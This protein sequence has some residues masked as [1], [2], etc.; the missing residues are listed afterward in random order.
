MVNYFVL[1]ILISALWIFRRPNGSA[2]RFL[3][4][5]LIFSALVIFSFLI[6]FS[7][8]QYR[9]WSQSELTKLL[10][11]PYRGIGYF[12]FYVGYVFFAPYLVSL[13]TALIFLFAAKYLNKKFQERF[14]EREEPYLGA[15]AIFL[16]GYPLCFFYLI[17]MFS[18]YLI[19]HLGLLIF[20]R[21]S[22]SRI[23]MYYLWL[24]LA[25]FAIIIAEW[26]QIFPVWNLLKI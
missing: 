12:I 11:P 18:F 21:D 25:I 3:R 16:V 14:F 10:L 26:F 4:P 5:L 7:I 22:S 19:V 6:Y 15:L 9:D 17:T 20:N 8:E 1:L 24:P 2:K 23:S 13:A